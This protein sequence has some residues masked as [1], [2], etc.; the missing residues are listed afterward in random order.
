MAEVKVTGPGQISVVVNTS[1][2]A[3]A[4]D[5]TFDP[6]GTSLTSTN[7]EGAVKEIADRFFQGEDTPTEGLNEGDLWYDK[8]T[9]QLKIYK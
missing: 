2:A 1:R 9:G 8:S 5:T 7:L 4:E 3:K 6:S